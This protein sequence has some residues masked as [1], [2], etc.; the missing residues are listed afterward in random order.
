MWTRDPGYPKT[1]HMLAKLEGGGWAPLD[2]SRDGQTLLVVNEISA[3]ESY[4]WLMDGKSGDKTLLTPKGSAN[5]HY[6]GGQFSNDGKGVYVTTDTESDCHRP[7]SIALA[8][9]QITYLT[10]NIP[11]DVDEFDLSDN[12]KMIA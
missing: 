5:V 1:D 11:W 12:G 9:T 3:E 2:W 4:L 8:P 7:N 6:A 10:S